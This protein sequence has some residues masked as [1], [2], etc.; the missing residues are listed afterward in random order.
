MRRRNDPVDAA[1]SVG[2][3]NVE[4]AGDGA[5]RLR[6]RAHDGKPPSRRRHELTVVGRR[7]I[8]SGVR[9]ERDGQEDYRGH[10]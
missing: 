1:P 2:G 8:G 6:D 4:R 7:Q 3:E 10:M 9:R 5:I